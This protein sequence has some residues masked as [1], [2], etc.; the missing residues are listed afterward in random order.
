MGTISHITLTQYIR[1]H[2]TKVNA[3]NGIRSLNPSGS[4]SSELFK[5]Q[6]N[7][8]V[9]TYMQ[10]ITPWRS[11]EKKNKT[12]GIRCDGLVGQFRRRKL[13]VLTGPGVYENSLMYKSYQ[14]LIF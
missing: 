5:R 4:Q 6:L 3:Q 14:I 7:R 12:G 11:Q 10:S 8:E 9:I 2:V 13:S 1:S